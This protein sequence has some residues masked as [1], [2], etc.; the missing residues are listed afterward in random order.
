MAQGD[1]TTNFSHGIDVSDGTNGGLYVNGTQV[2]DTSGVILATL[3]VTASGVTTG[4]ALALDDASAITT[5]KLIHL[6][7]TGVTQTSGILLHI[8]SAS[9]ALTSAGRLL[10]VDHTG[11]AGVSNINSEFKSAAADE[12]VIV[13]MLASAALAAGKVLNI[14]AA[15]M[16][17]GK[18]ISMDTLDALTTGNAISVTSNSSSTG[19]RSLVYVKNDHASA[20]NATCLELVND[21]PLGC[22]KTT[23]GATSTNYFKVGVFNGVTLWVGNGNTANGT[24]SGT[25]GDVMFNG[26]SSKIEYCT[27]TTNWQALT[28]A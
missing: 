22:I 15:A 3:D 18:G 20:V 28:S 19:T 12:T 26:A 17:T 13:Q 10:L 4:T 1:S 7:A 21:A 25:A 8:D 14:S 27:G 2:I 5:G 23:A 11:N 6:D 16:T 9:T 24:L